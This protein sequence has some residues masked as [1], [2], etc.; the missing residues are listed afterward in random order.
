MKCTPLFVLLMIVIT[1]Y[2]EAQII[3]TI[4]GNGL[5]GDFGS[6]TAASFKDVWNVGVDASGNVY[7][8]DAGNNRIRKID[9]ITGIISTIAGNGNNAYKGD[10]GLATSASLNY[11]TDVFIAPSGNIYIADAGNYV[12]RKING[13]TGIITTVAGVGVSGYTGDGGPAMAAQLGEPWRICVDADE[14]IYYTDNNYYVVRK[15]NGTTGII[16]TIAGNGTVGF[17]GD[18]GPATAAQLGVAQDPICLDAS[19]NIYIC[20]FGNR[21][22][23]KINAVT[24]IINTV[25]GG[26]TILNTDGILATNAMLSSPRSVSVDASNNIYIGDPRNCRKV[27][28][29]TGIISTVVGSLPGVRGF[30]GD[31]GLA[32]LATTNASGGEFIDS[33]GN[34]YVADLGNYR[35]RKVDAVTNIINTIGGN[36]G[37]GIYNGDNILAATASLSNPKSVCVDNASNIYIADA[38]NNRI[39]K[40][41]SATGIISTIAGNGTAGI[42]PDGTLSTVAQITPKIIRLDVSGNIYFI[43]GYSIRK[44]DVVTGTIIT[45]AGNGI[46][47]YSGDGGPAT[48]AA[49]TPMDFCIDGLGNIFIAENRQ[50]V[51]KVDATTGVISTIAGNGVQASGTYTGDGGPA[52]AATFG[53]PYA[54]C[55]D[56]DNNIFVSDKNFGVVRKISAA[57]GIINTV[58]GKGTAASFPAGDGG[59]ATAASL[60]GP[61]TLFTDNTGNL[62]L[63]DYASI[64]KVEKS[65]GIITTIAGNK[66]YGFSG[67]GGL[68]TEAQ[69]HFQSFTLNKSGTNLFIADAFNNRIRKVEF[70]TIKLCPPSGSTTIVSNLSG[71]SYQW[72]DDK[73]RDGLY[74][75]ITDNANFSK[76]NS[77]SIQLTNIPSNWAGYQ[78]RCK[79]DGNYTDLFTLKFIERWTGAFSTA[80][81]NVSNWSCAGLPDE[82]TDV[83][84]SGNSTIV[85]NSNVTIRSLQISSGATL[86]ISPG[87]NLTIIQ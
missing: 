80:W 83:V 42:S 49:I 12:I 66:S 8:A 7:V 37:T 53:L 43:E 56:S 59:A 68:P 22:I 87:S 5:I 64:R 20:D 18:G 35:V 10:G 54:I 4:A 65:T 16:T 79:V 73:D 70:N 32:T 61:S 57:T 55:V 24:G 63:N 78:L 47:N 39:R 41:S 38:A 82:N 14:N 67:D 40:I 30:S 29:V 27:D 25:A 45:V 19:K 74:T 2:V 77:S 86:I 44:I 58:A 75:N 34:I 76:T 51:R 9:A 21:R 81:D 11:P 15:I 26:G 33:K 46:F 3:N 6:A 17:S 31:G 69:F 1:N 52:T 71:I 60:A 85:V 36:G 84:I 62:Y 72:Q 28:A 48:S 13:S 23:R 50:R